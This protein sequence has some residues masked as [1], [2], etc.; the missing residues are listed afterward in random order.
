MNEGSLGAHRWIPFSEQWPE[1]AG[2]YLVANRIRWTGI[3]INPKSAEYPDGL[4]VDHNEVF[5]NEAPTHWAEGPA[6]P[7]SNERE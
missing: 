5:F 7:A 3:W 2:L 6:L 4:I 1:E